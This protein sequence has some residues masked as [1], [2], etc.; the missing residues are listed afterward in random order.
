VPTNVTERSAVETT[1]RD[2]LHRGPPES[3]DTSGGWQ[4][5][6]FC[7]AVLRENPRHRRAEAGRLARL[8][9]CRPFLT[10]KIGRCAYEI[11]SPISR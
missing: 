5:A 4:R 9:S 7:A 1:F 10:Q 3:A 8:C 11:S 6:A 2:T